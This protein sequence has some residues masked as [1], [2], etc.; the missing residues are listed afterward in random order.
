MSGAGLLGGSMSLSVK[1]F[2]GM[3]GV[4]R[5]LHFGGLP[6][7]GVENTSSSLALGMGVR[8]SSRAGVVCTRM[9]VLTSSGVGV[10]CTKMG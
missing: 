2:R 3:A 10:V 7:T 6:A 1:V 8:S 9:G 5:G 4:G